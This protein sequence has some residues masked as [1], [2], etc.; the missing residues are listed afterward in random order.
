MTLGLERFHNGDERRT[1]SRFEKN[2]ETDF[3]VL[4]TSRDE[5]HLVEVHDESLGGLALYIEP[6]IAI[7]VDQEVDIIYANSILRGVVRYVRATD[8]ERRLVGFVCQPIL[9]VQRMD[10]ETETRAPG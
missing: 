8:S 7:V 2:A 4:Y 9:P 6:S 10:A 3:A 5:P 1:A